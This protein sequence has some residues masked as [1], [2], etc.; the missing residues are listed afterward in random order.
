[1]PLLLKNGASLLSFL[2]NGGAGRRG[3]GEEKRERRGEEEEEEEKD[4]GE[5]RQRCQEKRAET[6]RRNAVIVKS[7][8]FGRG[9]NG[10]CG[11]AESPENR[12]GRRNSLRLRLKM[13]T[14]RCGC[15]VGG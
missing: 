3:E 9:R 6:A 10:F 15:S 12:S 4:E 5:E 11:F 2:R 7:A 8:V 13:R 14:S 1:M